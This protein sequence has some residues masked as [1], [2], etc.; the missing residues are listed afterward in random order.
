M[1]IP[2]HHFTPLRIDI[3]RCD[4]LPKK[5]VVPI[6]M[7]ALPWAS[8]N[9]SS[10]SSLP[11]ARR[12][13]R[14]QNDIEEIVEG[15]DPAVRNRW[16]VYKPKAST[17]RQQENFSPMHSPEKPPSKKRTVKQ[18]PIDLSLDSDDEEVSLSPPR[19]KKKR[20]S[21]E[22]DEDDESIKISFTIEVETPAPPILSVRQGNTEVS[23]TS[24]ED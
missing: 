5:E 12:V 21:V 9:A 22:D 15:L 6:W 13:Q 17:S 19:N 24:G 8:N 7:F 10:P 23:T 14:V 4:P 11:A 3:L 20:K 1:W 2:F 18:E 16:F